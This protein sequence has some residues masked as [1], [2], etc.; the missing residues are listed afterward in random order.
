MVP[1]KITNKYVHNLNL[2]Y[3]P[4]IE[5]YRKIV[6]SISDLKNKI[7]HLIKQKSMFWKMI[8]FYQQ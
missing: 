4:S 2:S 8:I 7:N 5:M 3:K 6:I 1:L